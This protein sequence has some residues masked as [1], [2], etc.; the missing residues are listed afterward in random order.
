MRIGMIDW[1]KD[2]EILMSKLTEGKLSKD[3]EKQLEKILRSNPEARNY[4]LSYIDVDTA[5]EEQIGIP[6][7]NIMNLS[8]QETSVSIAENKSNSVFLGYWKLGISVAAAIALLLYLFNG[9]PN[10]AT[11]TT[12]KSLLG[13]VKIIQQNGNEL[14]NPKMGT[15]I[16][17][18]STIETVSMGSFVEL[19][20]PDQSIFTLSDLS[21]CVILRYDSNYRELGDLQFYHAATPSVEDNLKNWAEFNECKTLTISEKKLNLV[22][23]LKGNETTVINYKNDSTGCDVEL[24]KVAGGIHV[25]EY[26]SEMKKM[27]I[28]WILSKKKI[29]K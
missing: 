17:T 5:L 3:E 26:S 13:S 27:M 12:I 2:L 19:E 9:N 21:Q 8:I 29:Y 10:S 1:K 18:G 15:S 14:M 25:E 4:Y 24:W 16:S 7:F 22:E 28:D 23:R 6:N 11:A 20:F